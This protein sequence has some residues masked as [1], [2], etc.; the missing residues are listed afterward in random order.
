MKKFLKRL[1]IGLGIFVLLILGSSVIIAGFFS[2]SVGR[3]LIAT[4]NKQL[5]TQLTV[6][7]FDLSILSTFPKASANLNKVKLTDALGG[8]RKSTRLNSSD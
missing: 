8:D 5:T 7:E 3:Q 1:L 4:I 6:G 2:Q